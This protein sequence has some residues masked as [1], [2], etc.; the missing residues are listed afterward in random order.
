MREENYRSTLLVKESI[1][2]G[3][4]E[5][6]ETP[7]LSEPKDLVFLLNQLES[8]AQQLVNKSLPRA[9]IAEQLL[10]IKTDLG[11]VSESDQSVILFNKLRESLLA[12]DASF[13]LSRETSQKLLA[14]NEPKHKLPITAPISNREAPLLAE[15]ASDLAQFSSLVRSIDEKRKT[16]LAESTTPVSL[17][18][19]IRS[20]ISKTSLIAICI[21]LLFTICFVIF[22]YSREPENRITFL[23]ITQSDTLI[24]L[25]EK[26]LTLPSFNPI[27]EIGSLSSLAYELQSKQALPNDQRK[28]RLKSTSDD[29]VN[30]RPEA[31]QIGVQDEPVQVREMQVKPEQKLPENEIDFPPYRT[32]KPAPSLNAPLL[33]ADGHAV[34]KFSIA[35][36]YTAV[37]PTDIMPRPSYYGQSVGALRSGQQILVDA[38]IGPWVRIRLADG[39]PG[40]VLAQDVAATSL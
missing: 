1:N 37:V 30:S 40:F 5:L 34:D 31:L 10:S 27:S 3:L 38:L 36:P 9:L 26:T 35:R 11:G 25:S 16:T 18:S 12:N 28:V 23:P 15:P 13:S 32:N 21:T 4:E 17:L 8:L 6:V 29:S 14:P 7:S 20:R 22:R 2:L 33:P 39:R 19:H 24:K